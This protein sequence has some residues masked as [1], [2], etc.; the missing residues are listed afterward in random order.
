MRLDN[1]VLFEKNSLKAFE[2]YILKYQNIFSGIYPVLT[3][4][5]IGM[6]SKGTPTKI[7]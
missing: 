4:K 7:I 2:G 5:G 1:P 3:P 6:K